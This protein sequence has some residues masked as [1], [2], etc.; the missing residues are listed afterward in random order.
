MKRSTGLLVTVL[1]AGAV[2]A[3]HNSVENR[4]E[5]K[6]ES[7]AGSDTSGGT[8]LATLIESVSRQTGKKFIIDPRLAGRAKV[9]GIDLH[10]LSYRELQAILGVN[11]FA[12]VLIDGLVHVVPDAN[13][14]QMP[15]PFVDKGGSGI[16][17]EDYVVSVINPGELTASSL[18]P[19]LHPILPQQA[20]LVADMQTNT[21]IV[22]ARFG[23]V[24]TLEAL[25]QSLNKRP[26]KPP[27]PK[28]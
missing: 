4:A 9:A 22:A 20:H 25:I 13:V 19:I 8:S 28:E 14:R 7:R 3:A 27:A 21:L 24:K 26:I 23:N 5:A 17:D 12:M 16:N 1:A 18:V 2:C 6:P 10:K 11:G 15:L